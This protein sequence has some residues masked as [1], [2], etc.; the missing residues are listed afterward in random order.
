MHARNWA[1][2]VHDREVVEDF[3]W[4]DLPVTRTRTRGALAGVERMYLVAPIGA[5]DPAP[6]VRPF[7]ERGLAGE[8]RRWC[9][10]ARLPPN[11]VTRSR[12]AASAGQRHR[13]RMGG[14]SPVVVHAELPRRPSR[15]GGAVRAG[16]VTTATGNGRIGFVDVADIAAVAT[17]ALLQDTPVNIEYVITEPEAV[18]YAEVCG[19]VSEFT[20]PDRPATSTSA[21]PNRTSRSPL[22][23]CPPTS[24]PFSPRWTK[25]SATGPRTG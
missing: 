13:P 17:H 10:S 21:Q 14:A 8:L 5:A 9:R 12:C 6:I 18:S 1:A 22:P 3:A 20:D 15:G 23:A 11:R 2:M 16:Q 19:L 7:L 25:P 24:R 4:V